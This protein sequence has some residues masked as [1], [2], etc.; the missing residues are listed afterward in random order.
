MVLCLFMALYLEL[1]LCSLYILQFREWPSFVLEHFWNVLVY[2]KVILNVP[3]IV[4]SVDM[5]HIDTFLVP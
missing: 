5:R 3:I 2:A 4:K 1:S